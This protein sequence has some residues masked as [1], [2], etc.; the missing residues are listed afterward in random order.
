MQST[1]IHQPTLIQRKRFSNE[2]KKIRNEP[3]GYVTAYPKV[4]DP[5]TWYILVVGQVGSDYEGGHFI[6]VITHARNYPDG[7][8]SYTMLTPNG[9]FEPNKKICTSNSSF[10]NESWSSTWNIHSILIGFNSMWMDDR[11]SGIGHIKV[12][13]DERQV[14]ARNSIIWN[15]SNFSEIY[16]GFNLE[17]LSFNVESDP[18][19]NTNN[20]SSTSSNASDTSSSSGSASGSY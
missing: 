4:D 8:P 11:D 13:R 17:S 20:S 7:A 5:F 19:Y 2:V 1:E 16:A 12:S 6:G 9:R 10:H 15:R 18:R 14:L 3:L